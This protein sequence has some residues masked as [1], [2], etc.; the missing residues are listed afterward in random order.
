MGY[1]YKMTT[2]QTIPKPNFLWSL[3]TMRC[4]RCR[5][6]DLFKVSNPYKSLKPSVILGMHDCCPVC[7]QKYELEP[8]F[9]YGTGY[10]SYAL[11]ILFSIITFIIWMLTIGISIDDNRIFLWLLINAILVIVLQPWFMRFSRA[12][13]LN[14]FVHYNKNYDKEEKKFD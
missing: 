7:A 3:F 5:R 10:V 12:V 8:G 9:W 1:T 14:F 13:Y 11:V 6:G 4:P 2:E